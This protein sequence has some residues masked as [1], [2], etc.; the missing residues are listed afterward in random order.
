M[1]KPLLR[2]MP[3]LSGNVKI[4]CH[5]NNIEKTEDNEIYETYIQYAQ[6]LPL[7]SSLFDQNID[8]SLLNSSYEWDIISFYK[9]Y[10]QYFFE[11]CFEYNKEDLQIYNKLASNVTR[12]TDFEFGVKRITYSKVGKQMSFFAPIYLESENDVPDYFEMRF[13]ISNSKYSITRKLRIN[14]GNNLSS[15]NY[16]GRYVYDYGKKIDENVI[17]I[18]KS[19]NKAYYSGINI[20]NGGFNTIEDEYISNALT[21]QN[22]I[23]N[24][25]NIICKGFRRNNLI[26]KQILPLCFYVNPDELIEEAYKEDFYDASIQI[27]GYYIKDGKEL[28]FYDFDHSYDYYSPKIMLLNTENGNDIFSYPQ[29]MLNIMN[30]GYPALREN[31]F[32]KYRFTNKFSPNITR[33]KLKYSTDEDP[34]ITNTSPAFSIYQKSLSNYREFPSLYKSITAIVSKRNCSLNV[35][36]PLDNGK[37]WYSDLAITKYNQIRNNYSGNWFEQFKDLEDLTLKCKDIVG[38]KCLFNGIL[39]NF[40]YLYN[41]ESHRQFSIDKFGVFLRLKF[42]PIND[43]DILNNIYYAKNTIFKQN[44][45]YISNPNCHTNDNVLTNSENE[46]FYYSNNDSIVSDEIS[47]NNIFVKNKDNVGDFINVS[48]YGID[49]YEINRFYR[50]QDILPYIENQY[51]LPIENASV[52]GFDIVP[53]YRASN[54]SEL[55]QNLF[56]SV[57]KSVKTPIEYL[58]KPE[59]IELYTYSFYRNGLFISYQSFK[60][61]MFNLYNTYIFNKFGGTYNSEYLSSYVNNMVEDLSYKIHSDLISYQFNPS[62]TKQSGEIYSDNVFT[63]ETISSHFYGDNIPEGM[64]HN[65]YDF[66]Y[67]D[68]YNL[69][70]IIDHYNETWLGKDEKLSPICKFNEINSSHVYCKFLN[71]LHLLYFVSKI[72]TDKNDK[73]FSIVKALDKIYIRRKIIDDNGTVFDTLI[74]LNEILLFPKP[75]DSGEYSKED[76]TDAL[77]ILKS[78]IL[79]DTEKNLFYFKNLRLYKDIYGNTIKDKLETQDNDDEE[80]NNYYIIDGNSNED[81]GINM[82]V[83]GPGEL[84]TNENGVFDPSLCTFEIVYERDL[85]RVDENI[86]KLINLEEKYK[87]PYKDLYLYEIE[88]NF[89][90]NASMKITY[91]NIDENLIVIKPN[92][93]FKPLFNLVTL[94]N[95][96]ESKIYTEYSVNTISRAYYKNY[97]F[98]RHNKPNIN[99]MYDLSWADKESSIITINNKQYIFENSNIDNSSNQYS[100]IFN[101]Y[102]KYNK[103]KAEFSNYSSVNKLEVIDKSTPV[104]SERLTYSF[105]YYSPL[106]FSELYPDEYEYLM[107]NSNITSHNDTYYKFTNYSKLN[108]I[109]AY[110]QE[111]NESYISSYDNSYTYIDSYVIHDDLGLFEKY[112]LNTYISYD[113]TTY[114]FYIIDVE[115]D[116]TTDSL[117]MTSKDGEYV[118]YVKYINGEDIVKNPEYAINN[119]K[120]LMPIIKNYPLSKL[121]SYS[122][123]I[124]YPD[125]F[126]IDIKYCPERVDVNGKLAYYDIVYNES[127][128]DIVKL[129]RYFDNVIPYIPKRNN[130][131]LNMLKFKNSYIEFKPTYFTNEVFYN[132][133][134]SIN[135]YPGVRVYDLSNDTYEVKRDIEYKFFNDSHLINLE[136]ELIYEFDHLL[137]DQEVELYQTEKEVFAIFKQI[138]KGRKYSIL[139]DE[140]IEWAFTKYGVSFRTTPESYN[141]F[142]NKKLYSLIIKFNLL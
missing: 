46:L 139:D 83:F 71:M 63:P 85:L 64:I 49:W 23:I 69:N 12:N 40:N 95:K 114:G 123:I 27:S 17:F 66:I 109:F 25:D 133:D 29:P 33:W 117:Y 6:I 78:N 128:K 129:N 24:F 138:L 54:V 110:K 74:K 90:Y 1:L 102:D 124:Q 94:E 112:N 45:K 35:I 4:V 72:H 97:T 68:P 11:K 92:N 108:T 30:I 61:E 103:N 26:M 113:G 15:K 18:N 101:T 77:V 80:N 31:L 121:F 105:S 86:W 16:L 120:I 115:F 57:G 135:R 127:I 47:T 9:R 111:V 73:N 14:I 65:D 50:A 32:Y 99:M 98:Y 52:S 116:N 55:P 125:T 8:I 122:N 132:Q 5:A 81:H 53:I 2:I 107:N 106:T 60:E 76:Q 100:Y 21:S 58:D 75:D 56:Y 136:P 42:T 96:D 93:I 7:T 87:A 39:Y 28:S 141:I 20:K 37:Q 82:N 91:Q 134:V 130:L 38:N 19:E 119:Y 51:W 44:G 62:L 118:K 79:F 142:E 59:S 10:P 41:E 89:E 36:L 88:E 126:N 137:T 48:D 104:Y 131:K 43:N 70:K 3:A 67:V 140:K 34:Y 13:N 22:T 84:Y